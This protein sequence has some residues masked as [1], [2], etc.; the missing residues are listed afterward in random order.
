[1][2]F[3]ATNRFDRLATTFLLPE[4]GVSTFHSAVRRS[5]VEEEA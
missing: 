1:V 2:A 4:P 3:D 5:M